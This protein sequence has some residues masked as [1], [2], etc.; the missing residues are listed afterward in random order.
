[1]SN[2][3]RHEDVLL[4]GQIIP[5]NPSLHAL[6]GN[7]S[8]PAAGNGMFMANTGAGMQMQMQTGAPKQDDALG[9]SA[10]IGLLGNEIKAAAQVARPAGLQMQ[11][12]TPKPVMPFGI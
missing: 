11:M 7:F 1:M 2:G 6:K 3:P 4:Q 12:P 8:S 9:M 5:A 10:G